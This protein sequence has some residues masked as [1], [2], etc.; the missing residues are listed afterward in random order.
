MLFMMTYAEQF[1]IFVPK[2]RALVAQEMAGM[3]MSQKEIS[4]RLM[5]TQAAISQYMRNVRGKG[6]LD[7]IEWREEASK[8]A[9]AASARRMDKEELSSRFLMAFVR[10]F[11]SGT[12]QWLPLAIKEGLSRQG[13]LQ[14]GKE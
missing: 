12:P 8:F 14:S 5:V 9:K 4:K 1:S 13:F 11:P 7:M 6:S 2:F 10:L 3:G